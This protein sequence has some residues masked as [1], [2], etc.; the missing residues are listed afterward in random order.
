QTERVRLE[1][2]A[3]DLRRERVQMTQAQVR[4]NG[5]V[6]LGRRKLEDEWQQLGLAQQQWEACLNQEQSERA[7]RLRDLGRRT[8][9]LAVAERALNEQRQLAEPSQ[10]KLRKESEGLDSRI[11]NQRLKLLAQE[12][13]RSQPPA[14]SVLSP[15]AEA[16]VLVPVVRRPDPEVPRVLV[17]LAGDL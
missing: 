15:A 4:F 14:D 10:L 11:R 13:Q 8:A 7:M 16:Q 3:D 9:S 2:E 6:E 1:R 5:E 17:R 12:Q